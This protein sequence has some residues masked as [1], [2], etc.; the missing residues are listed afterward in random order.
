MYM[1]MIGPVI[2]AEAGDTIKVTFQNQGCRPFSMQPKDL[3][4]NQS[5][6]GKN[7][8]IMSFDPCHIITCKKGK[9]CDFFVRRM[10]I[11]E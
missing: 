2:R 7:F 5:D 4:F 9:V 6:S 3:I 8:D 11:N 1:G 10:G